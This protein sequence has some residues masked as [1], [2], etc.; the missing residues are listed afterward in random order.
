LHK[1]FNLSIEELAIVLIG[2]HE[3]D[4]ENLGSTSFTTPARTYTDDFTL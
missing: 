2:L 1:D 4:G 3:L